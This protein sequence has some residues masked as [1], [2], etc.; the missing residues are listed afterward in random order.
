MVRCMDIIIL[1][2]LDYTP[3]SITTRHTV[4]NA[5]LFLSDNCYTLINDNTP[6]SEQLGTVLIRQLFTAQTRASSLLHCAVISK[7][8]NVVL[9]DYSSYFKSILNPNLL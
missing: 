3:F 9:S 6:H 1:V 8:Y 2:I 7:C 5:E 4:S